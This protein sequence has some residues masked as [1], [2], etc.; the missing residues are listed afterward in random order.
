MRIGY[1]YPF[2]AA[3]P[4]GGNQVHAF[5]LAN[6]FLQRGHTVCTLEDPTIDGVRSFPASPQGVRE[7]LQHVDV[8]CLRVDANSLSMTPAAVQLVQEADVPVVWEINAPSNER[9]AFSWLGGTRPQPATRFGKTTDH[10]RRWLHAARQLPGIRREERLR[11]RLA[12]RAA[13]AICVSAPLAHYARDGL[14]I[15]RVRVIPNGTDAV[16][17][18]PGRTPITLPADFEGHFKVLYAGSPMYPWQGLDIIADAIARHRARGSRV[19]YMLL[20]NQETDAV[21]RGDNVL[22]FTRVPYEEVASHVVAADACVAIHKEFH[23]SRWGSHGSPMKLSDYMACGRPILASNV[24]QLREIVGGGHAGLLFD[25]TAEQ[26]CQRID[27]L[28]ADPEACRRMGRNA[29][30]IVEDRL[31][32]SLIAEQTLEL[33]EQVTADHAVMADSDRS[34]TSH[35]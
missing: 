12:R 31:N 29:R 2:R 17:N 4:R 18:H 28:A 22:L 35:T 25:N 30:T 20:V 13:A 32:W 8:L 26:L 14:G 23:W 5:Q 6:G 9:L 27:E 10:V 3:P 21:P 16:L 19:V 34:G 15:E 11:Q 33:L 7:L 1:I 24:G